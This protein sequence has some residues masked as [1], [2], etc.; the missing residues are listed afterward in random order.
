VEDHHGDGHG[1]TN[2]GHGHQGHG[3]GH[4]HDGHGDEG[5]GHDGHEDEGHGLFGHAHSHG[6]V[7]VDRALED[8]REGVRALKLS[9]VGLGV[10][11]LLQAAVVAVSG[12][13]ALLSDTLHN[14]SDA[15]TALP[16]WLA[17]SLGRRPATRRFTY[18]FGRAEDVAG[19]FVI[20]MIAASAVAAAWEAV[21]RLRNPAE[22]RN[23]GLVMV[24]A[25][26]GMAGNELV[27]KYRI[28]VG[29]RIGSAALVADGLHARADGLTSLAVLVGAAGVAAG[30]DWADPAIGLAIAGAI[31]LVLVQAARGVGERLMDAVSPDLVDTAESVVAGVDGVVEVS[32]L[33]VRW[34][35]H[36][37]QAEAR[38]T[39]DRDL[40]V[41]AAHD[42]A[43][44]AHHALLHRLPL[45]A[46]AVVHIDPCRHAGDD[47]H[48]GTA[49]HFPP[50]AQRTG[51]S[52]GTAPGTGRAGS[53]SAWRWWSWR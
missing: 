38:I 42:I 2:E 20:L 36:R 24:A 44:E 30:W 5:D 11:A 41:A 50:P 16:L 19:L 17:F 1:H 48:A 18:G 53:W 27:A 3:D 49:H 34:I 28:R 32:E 6:Q 40:D 39:V 51:S 12:S 7:P 29:R 4:G 13:V 43:E 33:R 21:D 23:L 14:I 47:P 35:G 45:L 37:L 9:L 52:R 46:S 26:I 31:V 25:V 8:N 15:L 10:T 22:V